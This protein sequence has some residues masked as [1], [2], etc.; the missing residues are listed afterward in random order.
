MTKTLK[1]H[2]DKFIHIEKNMPSKVIMFI[3]GA[4]L[5]AYQLYYFGITQGADMDFNR[6]VAFIS[7]II[8]AAIFM[9]FS[10]SNE[11][12]EKD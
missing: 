6:G 8:L 7:S 5:A 2:E 4:T 1:E 11:F 9:G 10:T 3:V 12:W